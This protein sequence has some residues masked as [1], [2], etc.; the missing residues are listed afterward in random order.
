M[1]TYLAPL[2][3]MTALQALIAL[4]LFAVP[5]LAPGLPGFRAEWLAL[6]NVVVFAVGP[7]SSLYGGLL[8]ARI[9]PL[10]VAQL[11]LLALS[12]AMLFAASAW[13][14][15]FLAAAILLGLA[16]GPETPASSSVLSATVPERSRT[17]VFSIRQTGNQVG[18]ML[19]SLLLPIAALT[20][21]RL[22]FLAIALAGLLACG[23]FEPL[24]RR[25]DEAARKAAQPLKARAALR[26]LGSVPGLGRLASASAMYSAMQVSLNAFLV[27][28]AVGELGF[29]LIE[30]GVLL[31]LAQG[32]GLAGRLGWGL[33]AEKLLPT[34]R[35]LGFLGLAMAG[36][37]LII[38]LYGL[39]IGRPLLHALALLFGLTASGW[40]GIF[41]AEIARL[42]PEGQV[43]A[44]TGAT[45][46]A[47][48]SGLLLGP[49]IFALFGGWIGFGKSFAI[50]ALLCVIASLPLLRR[51]A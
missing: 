26:L 18:A 10:R 28:Y 9:G 35:L 12:A 48:Y 24:R 34:R 2:A 31:A 21:W 50:I 14:W 4:G 47:A 39:E 42:A 43:G 29:S 16:F 25:L 5:V 17:I 36:A 45:L 44:A 20:D 33:I 49:A 22:G 46:M 13:P 40:N 8:C 30:A 19:G 32:G 27:A 15:A 51:K 7:F 38:G 3:A 11:S 23:L 6:F 41:I 37:A 1:S